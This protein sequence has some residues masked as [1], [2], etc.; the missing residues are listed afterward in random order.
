MIAGALIVGG[1]WAAAS[2][3]FVPIWAYVMRGTREHERALERR[4]LIRA[5]NRRRRYAAITQEQ[6]R[7]HRP[8]L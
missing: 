5:V 6:H 7:A 8:T 2:A 4:E 3:A 1:I